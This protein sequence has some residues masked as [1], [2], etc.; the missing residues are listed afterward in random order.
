MVKRGYWTVTGLLLVLLM[1]AL[2]LTACSTVVKIAEKPVPVPKSF[3]R[4]EPL[5][6]ETIDGIIFKNGVD[7]I[8]NSKSTIHP[9]ELQY[10][11]SKGI[12]LER[13]DEK[14]VLEVNARGELVRWGITTD[15]RLS[16]RQE[17][18]GQLRI[19]GPIG[20]S[21]EP[22]TITVCFDYD[23]RLIL[24]FR[25]DPSQGDLFY[26]V[27]TENGGEKKV[28]YGRKDYTLFFADG[29]AQ[30]NANGD[31]R[32]GAGSAQGLD[33]LDSADSAAETEDPVESRPYLQILV[34]AESE[35]IPINRN[36]DGRR[37]GTDSTPIDRSID[38]R[39][40]G[41]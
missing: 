40:V 23:E 34:S 35:N 36:I 30:S 1:G 18:P 12:T 27:Y 4:F 24:D 10:Y 37:V 8:I 33:P 29:S 9:M 15:E 14:P 17:T 31:G 22:M 38:G 13:R 39:R 11:I 41:D 28:K 26:L 5:T 7:V 6:R 21:E 16:L 20:R 25:Q 2:V 19:Y 32:P 3:S